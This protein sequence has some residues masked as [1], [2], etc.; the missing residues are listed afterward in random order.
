MSTV[1]TAHMRRFDHE[2]QAPEQAP[3]GTPVGLERDGTGGGYADP[4][5][6]GA[7]R[8]L[9][10]CESTPDRRQKTSVVG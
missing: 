10:R 4:G 9:A 1:P 7:I 6:L 3:A 5:S 8:T 2:E